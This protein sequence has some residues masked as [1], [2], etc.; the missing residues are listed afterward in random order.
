MK[1]AIVFP[2]FQDNPISFKQPLEA[3][4]YRYKDIENAN[5]TYFAFPKFIDFFKE[6]MTSVELRPL[7]NDSLV[8]FH[9]VLFL[10]TRQTYSV[11]D[12]PC[13]KPNYCYTVDFTGAIR[14]L[15][16]V[17]SSRDDPKRSAHV[18]NRLGPRKSSV[19]GFYYFPWSFL[20]REPAWGPINE[21]GHRIDFDYQTLADR[22]DNHKVI[23]CYGGSAAWAWGCLHH[24][25]WTHYLEEKLNGHCR[26]NGVPMKFT[27]LNFAGP[28]HVILN[29]I[30]HF[31]LYGHRVDF[32]VV[33]SHGGAN[34][35]FNG[36]M[37]DPFL[38][39]NHD[40]TYQEPLESWAQILNDTT[41]LPNIYTYH[42]EYQTASN[43]PGSIL[44]SYVARARQFRKLAEASGA[45]FVWGLQPM[46]F[47]KTELNH[48]EETI[49]SQIGE[50]DRI[51]HENEPKL[52]QMLIE[53]LPPEDTDV[54]V[55]HHELFKQFGSE[56]CLFNDVVHP[57]PEGN[58]KIAELYLDYLVEKVLP[59]L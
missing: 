22:D 34:D 33:I 4:V 10:Q 43:Q 2:P 6:F 52:Y 8:P 50:R 7:Q 40:I 9:E 46:L 25:V 35:L 13:S 29:E 41:D 21:F 5:L 59:E 51:T 39:N 11:N 38:L 23:A 44:K 45:R 15:S 31:I 37:S 53:N 49:V 42:N 12:I 57:S 27:V 55:N 3:I 48:L 58:E 14:P 36:Q 28:S 1:V 54:F 32:D 30:F 18:F 20:F 24:Q 47:S 56:Q 17:A 26:D 16:G 19:M